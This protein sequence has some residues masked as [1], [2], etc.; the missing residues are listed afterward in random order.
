MT[1]YNDIY[2]FFTKEFIETQQIEV[3]QVSEWRKGFCICVGP[4]K[5]KG[6]SVAYIVNSLNKVIFYKSERDSGCCWKWGFCIERMF[7]GFYAAYEGR[8]SSLTFPGKDRDTEYTYYK[9][10][11]NIIT[12]D[13]IV[14]NYDAMEKFLKNHHVISCRELFDGI[15]LCGNATYRL[16]DYSL[17]SNLPHDS[18]VQLKP[19]DGVFRV[20]IESDFCK[21]YVVVKNHKIIRYFK[22]RDFN[23]VLEISNARLLDKPKKKSVQ[24][25]QFPPDGVS[26]ELMECKIVEVIKDYLYTLDPITGCSFV[27]NFPSIFTEYPACVTQTKGYTGY[28]CIKN[29]WFKL[30]LDNIIDTV[31]KMMAAH[32][33]VK[34]F[35]TNIKFV[36]NVKYGGKTCKLYLFDCQ[37][38]GYIDTSG[39]FHYDFDVNRIQW[40]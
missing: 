33:P 7:G 22:E 28:I 6:Y 9:K 40:Y 39:D 37:P 15:V 8:C 32:Y 19:T 12:E 14:L 5:Q 27:Y 4:A 25:P 2:D 11:T 34:N 24:P 18:F 26:P 20:D 13:G 3:K 31:N 17:I 35:I 23:D 29:K 10:I 1:I 36:S 38:Y 30:T 21:L 16:S